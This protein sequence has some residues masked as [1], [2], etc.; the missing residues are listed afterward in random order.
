MGRNSRRPAR[1]E[2]RRRNARDAVSSLIFAKIIENYPK[3]GGQ[4]ETQL[5]AEPM[6]H[7]ADGKVE[8]K[9]RDEKERER[10]KKP[11][12]IYNDYM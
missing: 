10:K 6:E 3:R 7:T 4:S 11:R 9:R 5:D 8:K 1:P 12:L 2:L